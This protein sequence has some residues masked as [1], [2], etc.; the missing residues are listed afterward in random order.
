MRNNIRNIIFWFLDYLKG[1]PVLKNLKEIKTINESKD[2]SF[3][4]NYQKKKINELLEYSKRNIPFYKNIEQ[5]DLHS[6]P[7][8]DKIQYKKNINNFCSNK[9]DKNKLHKSITSGSTGTPFVSYQNKEKKK[10]NTADTIY[11]SKIAGY[12][13][14]ETLFY[15]KIWSDNNRKSRFIQ[16]LQN[17]IP[18]DVIRLSNSNI[19]HF[20]NTLNSKKGNIHINGYSSSLEEICKYF[21]VDTNS[22][23]NKKFKVGSILAQ[24]ESL[25]D[26]TKNR[27]LKYFDCLPCSRYS[28]LENGIIAQQT[29]K[30]NNIFLINRASYIVEIL[31]MDN[32]K[33]AQPNELGRIVVTDLTNYAMPFIRYD[34]GDIGKFLVNDDRTV[35][36]SF[37]KEIQGRK[38]DLLLDAKG[39]IV[40][41]YIVYKNMFK[42]PEIDQYQLVQETKNDYRFII[43]MNGKFKREDELKK[44]FLKYLGPDANFEIEYV[45]EIP[46]L[47]SGKRRKI[48]NNYISKAKYSKFYL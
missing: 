10:R 19:K 12:N 41:S 7:I 40:S 20:I 27:L 45:K 18:I 4:D 34:T 13:L 47:N 44:E 22:I 43:S 6:L 26:E 1:S 46:L 16:F 31:K 30:N 25:T 37:L 38:L 28:N 39:K 42:Y 36:H 32:D 5:I 29:L 15:L 9:F 3:I 11:F 2:N 23:I 35:N 33:A 17:I 14:G 8:I 21:D 24:S 48:L